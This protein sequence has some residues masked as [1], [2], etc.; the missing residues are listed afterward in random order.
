MAT[1][2]AQEHLLACTEELLYRVVD[3]SG[4]RGAVRNWA[5]F[6]DQ[7]DA[8]LFIVDSSSYNVP[9]AVHRDSNKLADALA[10]FTETVS[11]PLLS[12]IGLLVFF[13]KSESP[14]A[15]LCQTVDHDAQGIIVAVDLLRA[16]LKHYPMSKYFADF[17]GLDNSVSC[18]TDN[19]PPV[20]HASLRAD[21]FAMR[22][23]TVP[24][25]ERLHQA[26]IH[27]RSQE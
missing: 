21:L 3:L 23:A 7:A 10:L 18:F 1:V 6:F 9:S 15:Q 20:A 8:I 25:C 4:A 24:P 22:R 19:A 2:G 12:K 27:K 14:F 5:C 11:H 17:S 13:N 26:A 16:K